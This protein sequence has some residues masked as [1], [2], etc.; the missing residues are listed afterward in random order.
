MTHSSPGSAETGDDA[1]K[2]AALEAAPNASVVR[3]DG[4]LLVYY[5]GFNL[6]KFIR[7][8][9]LRSAPAQCARTAPAGCT[10]CHDETDCSNVDVCNA[11]EEVYAVPPQPAADCAMNARI[12]DI[13]ASKSRPVADPEVTA[14]GFLHNLVDWVWIHA[15]EGQHWPSS[16]TAQRLIALAR[17]K[18]ATQADADWLK[19]TSPTPTPPQE[20][21][22]KRGDALTDVGPDFRVVAVRVLQSAFDQIDAMLANIEP[23]LRAANSVRIELRHLIN[24]R[25][26]LSRP[27]R[28]GDNG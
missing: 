26:A 12:G 5:A 4:D 22:V 10:A 13:V 11:V 19:S 28:G 16:A 3:N 23:D 14:G 20:A 25:H 15:T 9:A 18:P 7:F 21:R 1:I 6:S 2:A 8:L 17:A 24:E 27:E